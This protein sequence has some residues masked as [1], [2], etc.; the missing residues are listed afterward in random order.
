M[1]SILENLV[2]KIE[3]KPLRD[4]LPLRIIITLLVLTGNIG[5]IMN[6][7]LLGEVINDDSSYILQNKIRIVDLDLFT[8]KMIQSSIQN[9]NIDD[10]DKITFLITGNTDTSFQLVR[11]K[12]DEIEFHLN[13]I[14]NNSNFSEDSETYRLI[15]E[16]LN[17]F[18]EITSLMNEF[19]NKEIMTQDDLTNFQVVKDDLINLLRALF[20]SLDNYIYYLSNIYNILN[21]GISNIIGILETYY[22]LLYLWSVYSVKNK[23]GKIEVLYEVDSKVFENNFTNYLTES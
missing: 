5:S 6:Q 21:T 18:N 2:N 8:N 1:K 20:N 4:Y 14:K 7:K 15:E 23:D 17:K 10:Q 22:I 3:S 11:D 16:S 12:I 19:K 13:N 9:I